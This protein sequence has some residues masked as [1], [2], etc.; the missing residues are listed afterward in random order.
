MT[1]ELDTK[2]PPKRYPTLRQDKQD[3]LCVNTS[4]CDLLLSHSSEIIFLTQHIFLLCNYVK[5]SDEAAVTL[6]HIFFKIR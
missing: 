4:C 3:K 2:N 5:D 6:R 1:Q